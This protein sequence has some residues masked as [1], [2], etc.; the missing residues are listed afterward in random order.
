MVFWT[1][2]IVSTMKWTDAILCS[3][4]KIFPY[5]NNSCNSSE[6][7][8]LFYAPA[9]SSRASE[10]PRWTTAVFEHIRVE[11]EPANAVR[12]GNAEHVSERC[13]ETHSLNGIL[14]NSCLCVGKYLFKME[15]WHHL[16]LSLYIQLM[17]TC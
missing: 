7:N 1:S 2:S 16:G 5:S 10:S 13:Y 3:P 17:Q 15:I 14:T 8:G 6:N 9:H 12:R 4:T 11:Q